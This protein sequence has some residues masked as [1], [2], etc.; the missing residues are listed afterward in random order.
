MNIYKAVGLAALTLSTSLAQA[1]TLNIDDA[2]DDGTSHASYPASQAID[3]NTAWASRWAAQAGGDAVNLTLDLGS[4]QTIDDVGVA[5]GRGDS[6]V[7]SFEIWARASSSDSWTKVL[8]TTESSGDTS[9]IETY[10]VEDMDAQYVRIKTHSNSSGSNW[11]N[12]LEAEVYGTESSGGSDSD[13]EL[14]I[15]TIFDDGSSH[16]SYPASKANDGS[17]AWASRWAAQAGGDAVNLTAQFD[18]TQSVT[19]VGVSWGQG[20]SRTH[21]FEIYARNATSGTWTKIH[22]SISSGSSTDIEVYDVT[23]IDAKQVRLKVQDTSANTN[24]ANVTE[25]KIYGSGGDGGPDIP[26][27]DAEYPSDLMDNFD[28]WK[29]TLPDGDEIKQLENVSN[30]YF[31]V[32]DDGNGIV[33]FAPVRSDNG[34]TPNSD[35]IRSE[36]RE[37]TEDGGSDI[38]WDTDG[39]H[40][41]YSKQAITHLPIV[42]SHLV[43]TQIHGNKDDGIDDAL[44]LRLEDSHLF[45]SFNGG[46]LRDDLTIKTN[47]SLGTVHEIMFEIVNGKHYVYYSEDGGLKSAYATGNADQY[48]VKDG[49]NDYVM[50]LDYDET[51]FKIGNYTQSNPDEEGSYTDNSSNYGEVIVYDF[52]VDH[53]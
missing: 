6:I 50:D 26:P 46:K 15:N 18:S 25:L 9:S 7:Y 44:V 31:Y 48:L 52:Y 38:Y 29:I 24:W 20:T 12:I 45:L 43:A 4:V 41:V 3:G 5:W 47:Y 21:T 8:S 49:S 28:Q 33:F 35:Y 14:T 17:S 51:Y 37:R 32:N 16:S 40:V 30:E 10:N 42:K 34:T 19:E 36:L 23:D 1:A 39:T 53:K 22:D 2:T 11:T 13:G 27:S